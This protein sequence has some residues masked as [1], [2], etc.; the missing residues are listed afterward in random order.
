[1]L[2]EQFTCPSRKLFVRLTVGLAP[3]KSRAIGIGVLGRLLTFA[4][5]SETIEVDQIPHFYPSQTRIG[6]IGHFGK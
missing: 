1:M 3:A 4:A 2:I 5:L 6:E